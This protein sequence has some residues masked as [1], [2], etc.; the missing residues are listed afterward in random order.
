[1]F[2]EIFDHSPLALILVDIQGNMRFVNREAEILFGYTRSEMEGQPIEMLVPEEIRGRHP[3]LRSDFF[4]APSP[5]SMGKGRNLFGVKKD[6]TKFPIEV[7]LNPIKSDEGSFVVSSIID[8]TGRLKA[9]EKFRTAVEAAPNG[10]VMV[11]SLGKIVLVN[12][13]TERL[14]GYERNEILGSPIEIL[15]PLEFRDRHPIYVNSYMKSP[16]PRAMGAGR[17]LFARKK[18]GTKF[19]VEIGLRPFHGSDGLY[20]ISSIVDITER[21][22]DRE[23]LMARNEELQQFAYRT[24]HDLKAP[25]ISIMGLA[26]FI[27]EDVI[28]GDLAEIS[29]NANKILLL[30]RKLNLLLGDILTLT[31]SD[32]ITEEVQEIIL[33]DVIQTSRQKFE[34]SASE[35]GVE[36]QEILGHSKSL[37][38][39]PTLITNVIDNLISNGI[40]YASDS[41]TQRFVRV[42]TFNDESHFHIQVEDNGLGIPLASQTEVFGMFK[43]FHVDQVPGSGLGLYLVKKQVLKL[44]GTISFESNERGTTFYISLPI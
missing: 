22:K 4:R 29:G 3:G 13:Q 35:K 14:F 1:M 15:V 28:S 37:V 7:G 11:D 36:I 6:Q 16:S 30:S 26:E 12:E 10:V 40:K 9:E 2:K 20:V 21:V 43:R 39:Q 25:L 34:I 19:P 32:F 42:K 44:N 33:A 27:G 5:R 18:D 8:I 41:R 31:K 24:S 23:R 17:D 38:S